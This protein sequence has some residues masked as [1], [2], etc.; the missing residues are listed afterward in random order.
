MKEK[1]KTA[2]VYTIVFIGG[3]IA[4]VWLVYPIVVVES[5]KK[6]HNDFIDLFAAI[7]YY[8]TGVFLY[9]THRERVK[10]WIDQF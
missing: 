9:K 8:S 4:I 2:F 5:P 7:G 1:L 6:W 10:K 3:I